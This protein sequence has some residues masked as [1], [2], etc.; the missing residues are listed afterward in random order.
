MEHNILVKIFN[1]F[2]NLNG[3]ESELEASVVKAKATVLEDE[4]KPVITL[5]GDEIVD[6]EIGSAYNDAGA[7]ATDNRVGDISAY[8][9]VVNPVNINKVGTYTVT[10]N[11]SDAAGNAA[12]EVI[13]TVEVVEGAPPII[14]GPDGV[15]TRGF[16]GDLFLYTV[17]NTVDVSE[18]TTFV[19]KF[20]ANEK[21][22][23]SIKGQAR[24]RGA[25]LGWQ[26][27]ENSST[28]SI[29]ASGNLSF[30]TAPYYENPIDNNKYLVA[31]GA[32]DIAGRESGQTVKVT[33][34]NAP[35]IITGPPGGPDAS[36]SAVSI[37]E[38]TTF[39]YTFTAN[40]DVTWNI[41]EGDD[42]SKF[43]IDVSGNLSFNNP[44]DYENPID[45]NGDNDYLVAVEAVDIAGLV[46]VQTVKVTVVNAPPIITGPPEGPDASVSAV[47][48]NENT[49]FVYTFTANEDVTWDISGGDD[50]SKFSIDVSGNLSFIDAP[51]Y[52]N[53]IDSNE[54]NDY[55]VA[56]KATDTLGN[57]SQQ[58]IKV[59]VVNVDDAPP[60]ITGP[61]DITTQGGGSP[62]D[63][64]MP[65]STVDVSEN[66]MFVHKFTA[67]KKVTWGVV[68]AN[69]SKFEISA[70]GV[71]SFKKSPD[72]ENPTGIPDTYVG[73]AYPII[74]S[75]IDTHNL[76]SYQIVIVNVVNVDDTHPIITGPSGGPDASVSA[77]SINENTT[78]V[79][80]FTANEDVT[81]NI[82]GG[83]DASKFSIDVSGNL[84]F[85][86]APDYENPIDSNEGNV[87]VVAVKAVDNAALAFTSVQTVTVTVIPKNIPIITSGESGIDIVENS[88]AGALV[89]QITASGS[90]TFTYALGGDDAAVLTVGTSGAVTLNASPDYE[91]KSRYTFTV[92]ATAGIVASD[93]KTVRFSIINVVESIKIIGIDVNEYDESIVSIPENTTI[94]GQFSVQYVDGRSIDNSYVTWKKS[95]SPED[96]YLY[97]I[98]GKGVLSFL[99][100]PSE[101][102]LSRQRLLNEGS[103][104]SI[105]ATVKDG[106]DVVT[107]KHTIRIQ[108]IAV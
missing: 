46:S 39:V 32:V 33:V 82:S 48:I 18:N 102:E 89:Y 3:C 7:T 13:R 81:W 10:Y 90:D 96:R 84:S 72:Y 67:N 17:D 16:V 76:V 98:N 83:D 86:D 42:A 28:F 92:T 31:V 60:I 97:K 59:I 49:T 85:I 47:S 20:T 77:V 64:N 74:I 29:D 63:P 71:L 1:I 88:G 9:A 52:E 61:D 35:P 15:K 30:K 94:V 23:W 40:E 11:V 36:V 66:T 19:H 54:G 79:Y 95:D 53:P 41:S 4:I 68:D 99:T 6:V 103:V 26:E 75:A 34:V 91:T 25:V 27:D 44:P 37:N 73:N 93:P 107:A 22:T 87:Y 50:A 51:D 108:T 12:K 21:V 100:A 24:W 78:F 65:D 104:M 14:T 8:I 101:L 56:V 69:S 62:F 70:D 80:T 58:N 105:V 45:S 106:D 38:N 43:S 5:V 57:F 55:L 2:F